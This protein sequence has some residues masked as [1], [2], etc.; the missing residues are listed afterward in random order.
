MVGK[1]YALRVICTLKSRIVRTELD[2]SVQWEE[3]MDAKA[4][5]R[6]ACR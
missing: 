5:S 3:P 1:N 6:Q 4:Q 2:G